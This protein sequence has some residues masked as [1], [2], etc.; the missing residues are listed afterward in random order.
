MDTYS[1]YKYIS[2]C[3]MFDSY[4]PLAHDNFPEASLHKF[5]TQH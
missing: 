1:Q 2:I 5:H 4:V 3:K